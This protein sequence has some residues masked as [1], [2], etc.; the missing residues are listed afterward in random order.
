MIIEL[1]IFTLLGI[2]VGTITGLVPGLHPNTILA[3]ILSSAFIFSGQPTYLIIAFI[4]SLSVTNVF[5]EF[6]QSS[7]F[8]A[9]EA[10]TELSVLPAHQMMM[11]GRAQ[12]AL[13]LAVVGGVGA[14][15][16]TILA[17]P[18]LLT[19]LPFLYNNLN[20]YIHYLLIL[21]VLWMIISEKGRGIFYTT[22]IFLL[23]GFFGVISLSS[24]PSTSI[25]PALAGMFGISG[26][27]L[28]L[29]NTS[30]IPEQK[31]PVKFQ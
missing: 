11:E 31:K 2:A 19:L 26:M 25:F 1:I 7:F 24:F 4:V 12:E 13:F 28:S 27:L 9:P 18:V 15:L 16:L 22:L 17:F 3:I 21:V 8:G 20:S 14:L 23:S 5:T 10:G 6:I 30:I 29:K